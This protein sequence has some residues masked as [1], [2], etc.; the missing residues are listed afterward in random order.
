MAK[1]YAIGLKVRYSRVITPTPIQVPASEKWI[2]RHVCPWGY[3]SDGTSYLSVK[4]IDGILYPFATATYNATSKVLSG[5]YG[6]VNYIEAPSG[7]WLYP[8]GAMNWA[9]FYDVAT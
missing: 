4:N 7:S 6:E 9:I 2:I 8:D 1:S 5:S 3:V